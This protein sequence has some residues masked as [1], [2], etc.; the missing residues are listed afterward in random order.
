MY[1]SI[2]I[3]ICFLFTEPSNGEIVWI[4]FKIIAPIANGT[5]SRKYF[6]M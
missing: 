3:K 1:V 4:Q 5:R 6:P 2:I